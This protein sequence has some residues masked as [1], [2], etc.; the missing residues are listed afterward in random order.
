VIRV[1]AVFVM[2]L[3]FGDAQ[4]GGANRSLPGGTPADKQAE[5]GTLVRRLEAVTW[6]PVRSELTWMVSVWN[7]QGSERSLVT[8]ERYSVHPDDAIMESQGE[9]RR[10]DADEA[11]RLRV[12][13]DVIST[14]AV[15]STIWWES[16]PGAKL[17]GQIIPL[18]DH[19]QG[20]ETTQ[21]KKEDGK[22][23]KDKD[24]KTKPDPK[25]V[26]GVIGPMAEAGAQLPE[27]SATV[28]PRR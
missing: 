19:D 2:F 10:F 15:E 22:A 28:R 21:D 7:L 8:K 26:P 6:N 24:Q 14:Y 16:G 27:A 18:P 9:H 23:D 4:E 20:K 12:L 13:M 11:K 5:R 25:V 17:E 1:L 3:S